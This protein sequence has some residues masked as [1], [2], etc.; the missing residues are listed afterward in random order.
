MDDVDSMYVRVKGAGVTAAPPEKKFY[1]V[2]VFQVTDPEGYTWG[3]MQR[4]AYVA[5]FDR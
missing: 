1:G 2:R 3:F 5:R 4:C